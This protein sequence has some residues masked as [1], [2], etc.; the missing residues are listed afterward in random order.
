MTREHFDQPPYRVLVP[1]SDTE[2][3]AQA[4]AHFVASLPNAP[5]R[6][7]A[8]L[9]HVL[10]GE[11]LSAPRNIRTAQRVGTVMHAR[12]YL[13]DNGVAVRIMDADDPYPPAKGI[14]ALADKIDA[15]LIV[16]G[17]G[18][19]GFL[20][21]LLTGQVTKSVSKRTSRPITI[22]SEVSADSSSDA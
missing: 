6:V 21:N 15:D 4:Q 17:G 14:V 1:V 3:S 7:E 20:D 18:M 13:R 16:L 5:A 8:T 11:E 10:H 2:T 9:T 12:D 19:H 22:V